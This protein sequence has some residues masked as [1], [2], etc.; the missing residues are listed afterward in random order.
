MPSFRAV[1]LAAVAA[2]VLAPSRTI[3]AQGP[4][5][6]VITLRGDVGQYAGMCGSHAGEDKLTGNMELV[7][8]DA[9]D[10]TALYQG[11]L[12]RTTAVDACGTRPNPTPDQVA[13]CF[14]HL[15]GSAKM[16]V[17]LEVYEDD[18]G[19]WVKSNPLTGPGLPVTKKISGCPE[20]GDWLNAY[21]N[22]GIMSGLSFED[23]PS[24]YLQARR[25]GTQELELVVTNP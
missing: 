16:N 9:E 7:S 6:V 1:L 20:P 4:V 24:G 23:V 21:P 13:M 8:Y 14:A 17:T 2:T 25:Y 19:A 22:D 12:D 11:T 10:G 15:D 3:R 18:R 5:N